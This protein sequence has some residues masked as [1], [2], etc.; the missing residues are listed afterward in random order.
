MI[1]IFYK[2]TIFL[3]SENILNENLDKKINIF[4]K[5][6]ELFL[7]EILFQEEKITINIY[8]CLEEKVFKMFSSY[9]KIIKAAGGIVLNNHNKILIINRFNV[10]DFPKGKQEYGENIEQT[11][12]REVSEEC[13][14]LESD[15]EIIEKLNISYHI[16]FLKDYYILKETNWYKMFFNGY[17]QLKPQIEEDIT[18]LEWINKELLNDYMSLSYLS[19][20]ELIKTIK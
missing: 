8:G 7:K 4:D 16:Y 5:K 13:G 12:I 17:Y 11:A 18:K 1:K 3:L 15:L 9:F 19:I 20:K 10:W 6:F 14:I 2:D